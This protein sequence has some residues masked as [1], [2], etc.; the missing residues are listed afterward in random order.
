MKRIK[1][2]LPRERVAPMPVGMFTNQ[3]IHKGPTVP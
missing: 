3:V 1:V 2:E